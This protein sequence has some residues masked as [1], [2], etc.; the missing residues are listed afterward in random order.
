MRHEMVGLQG[1]REVQGKV[2]HACRAVLMHGRRINSGAQMAHCTVRGVTVSLVDSARVESQR[3]FAYEWS[4]KRSIYA[5]AETEG[6]APTWRLL[7][8]RDT[9]AMVGGCPGLSSMIKIGSVRHN[10]LQHDGD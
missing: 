3:L 2:R 9:A 8:P 5:S 4:N 10:P 6:I 1:S 7:R